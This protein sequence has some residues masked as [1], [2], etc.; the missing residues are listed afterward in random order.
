MWF[1][2]P[3][4]YGQ[5]SIRT[6]GIRSVQRMF[7]FPFETAK[8]KGSLFS[9]RS[10]NTNNILKF[11][12]YRPGVLLRYKKYPMGAAIFVRYSKHSD[13]S[14]A[15]VQQTF[16]ANSR[17]VEQTEQTFNKTFAV[18][19]HWTNPWKVSD[20]RRTYSDFSILRKFLLWVAYLNFHA[21]LH[22]W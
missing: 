22:T 12:P 7:C 1:V 16:T 20:V 10:R 18:F 8:A 15:S 11:F 2:G 5:V 3:D 13:L 14:F 4:L 6:P 9:N 19:S 21:I 17:S